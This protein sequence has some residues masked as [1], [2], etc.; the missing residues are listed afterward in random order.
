MSS[1]EEGVLYFLAP[2]CLRMGYKLRERELSLGLKVKV[3]VQRRLLEMLIFFGGME[4][5]FS[6]CLVCCSPFVCP[7]PLVEPLSALL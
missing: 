7:W 1:E 6:S 5:G 3:R 2:K 4:T